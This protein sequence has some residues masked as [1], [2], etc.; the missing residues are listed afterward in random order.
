VDI[1]YDPTEEE[2]DDV[3]G[4]IDID[5]RTDQWLITCSEHGEVERALDGSRE[6]HDAMAHRWVRHMQEEHHGD[7]RM[8]MDIR[9][10]L[11]SSEG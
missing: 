9:M 6:S 2:A 3:D 4:V 11:F 1:N 10:M 7:G 5:A 8:S